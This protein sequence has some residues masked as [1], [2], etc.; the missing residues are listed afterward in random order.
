MAQVVDHLV[1]GAALLGGIAVGRPQEDEVHALLLA[2]HLG[3]APGLGQRADYLL[4][5]RRAGDQ[6]V[7]PAESQA[8]ILFQTQDYLPAL[9]VPAAG[10]DVL[11][12][13][14][15]EQALVLRQLLSVEAQG[16]FV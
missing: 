8:Y 16:A 1:H 11:D 15:A 13:L 5:H 4:R 10:E 14:R 6:P 7:Q 12:A 3:T 9:K 2:L